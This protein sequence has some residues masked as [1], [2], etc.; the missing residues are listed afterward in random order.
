MRRE[1]HKIE[2]IKESL[3][4]AFSTIF[5]SGSMLACAGFIIGL[6]LTDPAIASI[7]TAL[8]RG[9]VIS[10]VL[11]MGILSQVLILGDKIIEKTSFNLKAIQ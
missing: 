4:V 9:T 10:I 8:G 11:V 5:T 6:I 2:A 7:R 3:N 1:K